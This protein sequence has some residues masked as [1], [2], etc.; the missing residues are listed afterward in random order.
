MLTLIV[1]FYEK[2]YLGNKISC[3]K[4]GF[5]EHFC[6]YFQDLIQREWT[7][8]YLCI[9]P[10]QKHT[11][12]TSYSPWNTPGHCKNPNCENSRAARTL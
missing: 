7:C 9:W 6:K 11:S 3:E 12:H 10:A 1:H 8:I 5:V 4:S 2:Q